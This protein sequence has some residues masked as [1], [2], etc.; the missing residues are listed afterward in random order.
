MLYDIPTLHPSLVLAPTT[1]PDTG[2]LAYTLSIPEQPGT[3]RLDPPPV[4]LVMLLDGGTTVQ[5]ACK[6][7]EAFGLAP[8]PEVVG[9]LV[10]ALVGA[11]F[12]TL[13]PT[14][15]LPHR[16]LPGTEHTCEGCG[17]SCEGH[18]VGP[19]P[20]PEAQR[21]V[22]LFDALAERVPR[23]KGRQPLARY[24]GRD[25]IFLPMDK[26]RCLYLDPDRR[27]AIHRHMGGDAKPSICRMFPATRI[28]TEDGLRVG[29]SGACYRHYRQM[30]RS[31]GP[32]SAPIPLTDGPLATLPP[33]T[34]TL[35]PFMPAPF[36]RPSP[37]L[38]AARQQ[39]EALEL[40]LLTLLGQ[41]SCNVPQLIAALF[42][43][44]LPPSGPQ[45]QIPAPAVA[46][47]R[48]VLARV[49]AE[50]DR[51]GS[52]M[53]FMM[54]HDDPE[55]LAGAY[56]RFATA[57]ETVALAHQEGHPSRA[58]AW[59]NAL[60]QW[61]LDNARRMVWL[62][63]MMRFADPFEAVAVLLLGATL[64]LLAPPD[65]GSDV[66][67]HTVD[68]LTT[69]YRVVTVEGGGEQVFVDTQES[70]AFLNAWSEA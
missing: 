47:A 2:R 34:D 35:A 42:E 66:V 65:D 44:E 70:I 69:W 33:V 15:A 41:S 23:L 8:P 6:R 57:L 22:D 17:R 61:T 56:Q 50:L 27:C 45:S 68:I 30:T 5:G 31:L 63:E 67:A 54:H 18:L 1:D 53:G 28:A 58:M 19:L 49:N 39:V 64:G 9:Q 29:I 55:G 16:V 51:E 40:R 52:F 32:P 60:E 59:P 21:V 10:G 3:L 7:A 20:I 14:H 26:G 12:A 38:T 11:G 24:P 62:R 36:E 43:R 13:T 46:Q 25:G 4:L 48:R 37:K